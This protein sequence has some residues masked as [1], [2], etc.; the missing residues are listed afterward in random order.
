MII[1][2]QLD[3]PCWSVSAVHARRV[4]RESETVGDGD[5][6]K[7]FRDC[8]VDVEAVKTAER[9]PGDCLRR[10]LAHLP[11][12]DT[13]PGVGDDVDE[14]ISLFVAQPVYDDVE[15]AV[16]EHADPPFLHGHENR[17]VGLK[18]VPAEHLALVE[19]QLVP[20]RDRVVAVRLTLCDIAPVQL[21]PDGVPQRAFS[22]LVHGVGDIFRLHGCLLSKF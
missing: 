4:G 2:E 15:L 18:R 16:T 21:F 5:A 6:A 9:L 19:H 22:R 8:A 13:P 12:Q 1:V 11:A 3:S 14:A 7:D 20:A 10:V 17:A